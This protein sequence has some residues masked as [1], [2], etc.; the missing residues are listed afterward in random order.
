MLPRAWNGFWNSLLGRG[1]DRAAAALMR[2]VG[3]G[4]GHFAEYADRAPEQRRDEDERREDRLG[5]AGQ[6]LRLKEEEHR[7][8]ARV[9]ARELPQVPHHL[10][11]KRAAKMAEENQQ[12]G[13]L[14]D[15]VGQRRA[16]VAEVQPVDR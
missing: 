14:A 11:A 5:G 1:V 4:L 9:L 12:R 3:I 8:V 7:R 2:P 15:Q 10:P 16:G 6:V 13:A